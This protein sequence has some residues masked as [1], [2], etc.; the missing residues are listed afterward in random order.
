LP[1]KQVRLSELY[2][3]LAERRQLIFACLRLIASPL[4]AAHGGPGGAA[5]GIGARERWRRAEPGA[6]RR[7][8]S[9][10]VSA[11]GRRK[12]RRESAPVRGGGDSAA[13]VS[14]AAV[15]AA[16]AALGGARRNRRRSRQQRRRAA[17]RP[18]GGLEGARWESAAGVAGAAAK[19]PCRAKQVAAG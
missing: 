4:A 13:G 3:N 2:G 8:G 15:P 5:A 9:G 6:G 16:V 14:A 1:L 11:A 12:R 18:S 19:S 17:A 7:G 10:G